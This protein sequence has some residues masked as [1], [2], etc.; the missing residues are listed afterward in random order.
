MSGFKITKAI[1]LD[2]GDMS[3]GYFYDKGDKKYLMIDEQ[4]GTHRDEYT[5][6]VVL[7]NGK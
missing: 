4:V 2:T 7:Y 5:N 3:E 6:V 1:G